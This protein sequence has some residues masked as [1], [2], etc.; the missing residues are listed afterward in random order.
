MKKLFKLTFSLCEQAFP[1]AVCQQ[2]IVL[3]N[4]LKADCAS[5]DL[6]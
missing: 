1:R 4:L 2:A 5:L 3:Y 6:Q